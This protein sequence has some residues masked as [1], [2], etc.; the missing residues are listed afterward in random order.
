MVGQR[1]N[2]SFVRNILAAVWRNGIASDYDPSTY[3]EIAGSRPVSVIRVEFFVVL[4]I[5]VQQVLT[6]SY[7]QE[8][9]V[10]YVN[11]L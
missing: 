5:N 2:F 3:Q 4:V 11:N 7:D 9:T 6:S 8:I 10:A 1:I